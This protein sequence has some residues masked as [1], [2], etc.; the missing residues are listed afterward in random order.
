MEGSPVLEVV[1]SPLEAEDAIRAGLPLPEALPVLPLRESVSFPET[2]NP[3]A[4]G[5]ERSIQLVNDVLGTNRMLVMVASRDPENETP[6]PED[7]YD[8]GVVGVV[9]RMVKIPD[10]SLRILVQGMQRVRLGAYV[11]EKPYLVA[12]I[13]ELPDVS[14]PSP[15]LEAL[16]RNVQQTFSQ[17]VEEIPYLPEELQL[18]VANIDDPAA[19]GHLIA[20]SLRIDTE[21]KQKLL[22]EVDV[23]KRLRHLSRVLA[24]ELEVVQLG[25]QIQSQVQS[26][27]DKGQREFLLRQQMKAIQEELGEEDEQLA[28]VNEL[29]ERI[30]AA[31][32]PEQAL[33]AAEREL[34]RL[35]KLPP[36]AAEHG[37]IRT[38]L[39]W[40]VELPWSVR[41]E[42]NLDIK[43]AR[44]V[45]DAD[46]YDLEKVKDRIL[47]YLAVRKLNPDSPGPILCFVG[48]PGVGKTSLGRSIAKALGREFERISVGGVRDEAEIR[49]HRRTY[50]GALPGTIVRA[51][52]D[53]GS[54]NPVF[55][56]DEI[57]K[58]GADFRGDPASAMLEVLDPAQ[59]DSFRDHYLDLEFDLS[60]VVFIATANVLDTIPGPLL[61]RMETIELAGYTL[62]EKKHI[63]RQYLV[64]R[65]IAA[66]GLKPSQIEFADAALTAIVEEYTREAGV[67]NLERQIGTVCRK[68]AR[69]VAEGKAKG[70]VKVSGKK[71][72]E[73]LGR[74]R[75]FAEQRRR[76]KVPGV[77]TGLAWTPTGGDVLFI[78]ATAMPGSG[79]LTITGQLGDV[80]KESAQAALS[81]VRGHW[82][83]IEPKLGEDW[84]AEHDIHVH[85]PAGAVP[86]DGPSAGVAMTVAL[87]S[88]VSGR[89]V[90][91]DVAM[92]G[93]VTLTGQ[94]LP[95]GGL[96]EK[97]LAAQRAG[98]KRVIVPDRN[99]GDVEEIPEHELGGLEFVFVDEVSKALD[100][101][102]S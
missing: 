22:E 71:A 5:Q 3:L 28:E 92:T 72:R 11:S 70:K 78:E 40:L 81:Y 47:E 38:Y 74:R 65:Q 32:L 91:N 26:E 42:D 94:V 84:F 61:D 99:A 48:P 95:I 58:M 41:T 9:A 66:N 37:V 83:E 57:D 89:A 67:R 20:G 46:H 64:G 60:D 76:T 43:H 90:R 12:G 100:V 29:R 79:K 1:D 8:V 25:T 51:L 39:E 68:V 80:M 21:E 44:K 85:V 18:A 53:A 101:A 98:I 15:E 45:L 35:E 17:I 50:I 75:V 63:A 27:V 13:T 59:N 33:K 87:S 77:A 86:K 62:D 54:S 82:A 36:A 34:S 96:K 2:L 56:I 102:L 7:L 16:T 88:L 14:K 31:Q 49:G 73:L 19:L 30:E 52:R 97:S 55:M 6:G 23:A 69:D 10:G 93:E 24:R 4:V